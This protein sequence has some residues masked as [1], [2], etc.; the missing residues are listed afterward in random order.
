MAPGIPHPH[1]R[2]KNTFRKK[3]QQMTDII[4]SK[5]EDNTYNVRQGEKL[6]G[7]L[8][9]DEALGLISALIIPRNPG[10]L[11]WMRTEREH[12]EHAA[13]IRQVTKNTSK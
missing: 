3:Q 9:Y 11:Q 5:N 2:R 13:L 7:P 6:S 1:A 12:Q 4:I 10:C 8:G